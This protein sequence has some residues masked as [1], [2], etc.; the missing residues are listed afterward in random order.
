MYK[1]LKISI[2]LIF[3]VVSIAF[4]QKTLSAEDVLQKVSEKL[5]SLRTIKYKYHQEYNYAS[6]GFFKVD[7]AECFL[8]FTPLD[9]VIGFK[10]QFNNQDKFEVYNGSELFELKKKE[11][12]IKV[13][14]KP[15]VERLSSA[16]LL[17]FSPLMLR[18]ALPTI[19]PDKSIVKS[20]SE[21]KLNNINAYLIE[22]T[23]NKAYIDSGNGNILPMTIDRKTIYRLIID[24]KSFM[25]IEFFRS[26]NVNKD[27]NKTTYS[28]IVEN[29]QPPIEK[30][31]YYSSYLNEYKYAETP[32]DNLI[33]AGEIAHEINLPLF[34]KNQPTTL[35]QF[36]GKVVLLEFWIFHCVYCQEAV[37]KLNALQKKFNG[38]DFKLL[39][40]NISD[41]TRLI[42][43]FIKKTKA[44]FPILSNGEEIAEKYGVIAY[45]RAVLIDKEGKVIY[46]GGF[47]PAKIEELINQNL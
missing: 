12:T 47:I 43:L 5:T 34:P 21:T 35:S 22:L 20:I 32:K 15:D 42:Q 33:K 8:E 26:N 13:E 19:I 25:P 17:Q 30:T 36:R 3:A 41:S 4:S 16:G 11:K 46:S 9:G 40:I 37:P 39:T 2:I 28:E 29:P 10:F 6:D 27:F 45:P 38:K 7:R 23:L 1:K 18:N 24:K 31:W 44:E 14:P